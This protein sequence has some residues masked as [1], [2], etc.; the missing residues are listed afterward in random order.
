MIEGDYKPP[1]N[2]HGDGQPAVKLGLSKIR[3]KTETPDLTKQGLATLMY[4]KIN[5]QKETGPHK[6]PRIQKGPHRTSLL[7]R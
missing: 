1:V 3:L 7:G 5:L 6:E 4:T 2:D